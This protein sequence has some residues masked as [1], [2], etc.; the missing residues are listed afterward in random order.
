MEAQL[1][2]TLEADEIAAADIG[3]VAG[4]DCRYVGQG[5]ELRVVLPTGRFDAAALAEF[6]VLHE[7]EYGHASHDPIEIVNLRL[8]AV[9][10]RPT[11]ERL[12]VGSGTLAEA[13]LGHGDGIFR[14]DGELRT[15]RTP[16]Y[17][18]ARLP[19]DERFAGPAVIFQRDTTT[20][21]P[22]GWHAC[23]DQA[24]NLLLTR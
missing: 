18:R 19:L 2:A 12:P 21:V 5:Y 9:G 17:D 4:L 15:F 1:R 16:H 8:T 23:A 6:H 14:A 7:Q 11:I 10:K 22:P 24:G 13:L 3:I 20:L